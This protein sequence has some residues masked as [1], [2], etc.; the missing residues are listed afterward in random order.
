MT[1]TS[2]VLLGPL[3]AEDDAV[4]LRPGPGA[5]RGVA[6]ALVSLHQHRTCTTCI[7]ARCESGKMHYLG[8]V[9]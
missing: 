8:V 5:E 9:S 6:E 3:G 1:S 2:M 7:D 4:R